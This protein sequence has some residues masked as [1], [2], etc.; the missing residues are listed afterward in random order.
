MVPDTV[1]RTQTVLKHRCPSG[2][3]LSMGCFCVV[4]GSSL[5]WPLLENMRVLTQLLVT[6]LTHTHTHTGTC[7]RSVWTESQLVLRAFLSGGPASVNAVK[8]CF[9]VEHI[10]HGEEQTISCCFYSSHFTVCEELKLH[11][12]DPPLPPPPP[13]PVIR[14]LKELKWRLCLLVTCLIH[15]HVLRHTHTPSLSISI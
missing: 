14:F 10:F 9:I 7:T 1:C 6:V 15:W 3:M 8:R 13:P 12:H 5:C 11:S 2:L 4:S